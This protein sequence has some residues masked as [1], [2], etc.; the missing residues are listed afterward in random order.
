[1]VFSWGHYTSP[2]STI[3]KLFPWKKKVI[4][5]SGYKRKKAGKFVCSYIA[6]RRHIDSKR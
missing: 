6:K 3:G 4:S 2:D 1:M 5:Q